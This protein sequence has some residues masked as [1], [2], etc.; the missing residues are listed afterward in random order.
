ML[1]WRQIFV[2][3]SIPPGPAESLQTL[4]YE[5]SCT[6]HGQ[7]HNETRQQNKDKR[8]NQTTKQKNEGSFDQTSK[9]QQEE[10]TQDSPHHTKPKSNEANKVAQTRLNTKSY[11]CTKLSQGKPPNKRRRKM[12]KRSD[13]SQAHL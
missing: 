9:N 4:L 10:P 12:R 3:S 7:S 11:D 6:T 5:S 1:C 8:K 2:R 13:V